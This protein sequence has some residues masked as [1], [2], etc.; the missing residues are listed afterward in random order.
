MTMG[1][2]RSEEQK[3]DETRGF[4]VEDKRRFESSGDP[5]PAGEQGE[6]RGLDEDREGGVQPPAEPGDTA[7]VSAERAEPESSGSASVDFS[8]FIVG[9]A[10]QAFMLLGASPD[11]GS[12]VVHKELDQ[13]AAMID[14]IAMLQQKT[15]ANLSEDEA[16]LVEEVLYELRLRYVAE[17]RSTTTDSG[18][19]L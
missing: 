19:K 13:A 4:K 1:E 2:D 18:D 11:P 10:Q 7:S 16:R 3:D 12:G 17:T 9:L 5:R 14:I 15:A 8:G 6:Q